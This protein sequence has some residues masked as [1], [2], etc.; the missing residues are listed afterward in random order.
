MNSMMSREVKKQSA[1]GGYK[2]SIA[3]VILLAL[4]MCLVFTVSACSDKDEDAVDGSQSAG[5]SP[6]PAKQAS[7][8]IA[9]SSAT[10]SKSTPKD[11]PKLAFDGDPQ[12]V[13]SSGDGVPGWIQIDLGQPTT[14][15]TIRLN[16]SQ[17]PPGPTTHQV[18]AGPTPDNLAPLGTLDGNTT[19]GQV[20][21]LNK[22]ASNVRYVKIETV[23][24]LSWVAWR[25]IEIYK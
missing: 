10:A 6:T 11:L 22:S 21:E 24:S 23:K 25:E 1:A 15:S 7:E 2:T 12:T 4:A 19:D 3:H 18:S 14:I 20:L 16:V 17:F 5:K 13:W 8:K 9:L